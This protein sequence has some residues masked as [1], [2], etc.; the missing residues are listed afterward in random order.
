MTTVAESGLVV[1]LEMLVNMGA[2]GV[3]RL[4]ASPL[5]VTPPLNAKA[6]P[7][8]VLLVFIVTA[9]SAIMVPLKTENVP[10]TA[11]ELT[12]QKMFLACAPPARMT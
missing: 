2:A 7:S 5:N 11:E 1:F 10:S 9:M 4:P 6:L 8:I 12:C 3:G